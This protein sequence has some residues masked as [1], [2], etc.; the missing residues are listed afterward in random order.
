MKSLR[1]PNVVEHIEEFVTE[2]G[3]FL[4]IV[5]ELADI[6]NM[7]D[8]LRVTKFEGFIANQ[9]INYFT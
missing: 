6:G 1:H 8:L 4:C 5:M 9:A 3:R 2:D 7:R